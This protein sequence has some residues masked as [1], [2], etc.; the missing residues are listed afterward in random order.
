MS[1]KSNIIK[2]RSHFI[3]IAGLLAAA[4]FILWAESQDPNNPNS[5]HNAAMQQPRILA[6]FPDTTK[7]QQACAE[8]RGQ[9]A[10]CEVIAP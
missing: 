5:R 3:F 2:G 6:T 4:A 10:S 9:A 1:F 8:L 7:A